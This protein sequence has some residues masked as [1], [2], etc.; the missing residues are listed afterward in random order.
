MLRAGCARLTGVGARVGFG[1]DG[2]GLPRG[3]IAARRPLLGEQLIGSVM[4]SSFGR[5]GSRQGNVLEAQ[6][7]LGH[8]LAVLRPGDQDVPQLLHPALL[9]RGGDHVDAAAGGRANEVGRVVDTNG[10]LTAVLDGER[11]PDASNRLDDRR[12]DTAVDDP[13]GRVMPAGEVQVGADAA[14]SGLVKDKAEILDP[15]P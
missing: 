14:S 10:E 2:A 15:S 11:G 7:P 6:A 4:A 3:I 5:L 12:V 8:V 1:Q 9:H 13:P